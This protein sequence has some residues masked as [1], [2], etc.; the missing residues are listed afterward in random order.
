MGSE[1]CI[2]DRKKI[3][4]AQKRLDSKMADAELQIAAARDSAMSE[5][6]GVAAEATQDIVSRLAGAKVTKAAAKKAVKEAMAHG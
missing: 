3:A 6:E 1:M 4:A 5:V 2:R